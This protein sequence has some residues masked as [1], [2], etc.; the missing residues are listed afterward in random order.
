MGISRI[1]EWTRRQNCNC[2]RNIIY[3]KLY[4]FLGNDPLCWVS[5][6]NGDHK[7]SNTNIRPPRKEPDDQDLSYQVVL[8]PYRPNSNTL[9]KRGKRAR[10]TSSQRS[11]R[12]REKSVNQT[13]VSAL[14]ENYSSP[15]N[16][17]AP[18]IMAATVDQGK[19]LYTGS[20]LL[21]R[22]PNFQAAPRGGCRVR[23]DQKAETAQPWWRNPTRSGPFYPQEC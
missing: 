18:V 16:Q 1:G 4:S 23:V 22:R 10:P 14:S 21:L 6:D 3:I 8:L 9:P 12:A 17:K 20:G 15:N 11:F 7:S 2:T 19:R 5:R 13:H